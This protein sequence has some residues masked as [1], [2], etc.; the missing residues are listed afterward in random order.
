M[1][2]ELIG[3][4][5]PHTRVTN[6]AVAKDW[7][8][9]SLFSFKDGSYGWTALAGAVRKPA[10]QDVPDV[11]IR[12][13]G[14]SAASKFTFKDLNSTVNGVIFGVLVSGIDRQAGGWKTGKFALDLRLADGSERAPEREVSVLPREMNVPPE[15]R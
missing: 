3:K 6:D 9:G 10:E 5:Y 8:P 12:R 7:V 4:P 2:S 1:A 13:F 14:Q 11:Y 15:E